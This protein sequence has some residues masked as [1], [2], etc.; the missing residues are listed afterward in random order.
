MIQRRRIL[1]V[2]GGGICGLTSA[3]WLRQLC[4]KDTTFLTT[5]GDA[6]SPV[7]TSFAW[8]GEEDKAQS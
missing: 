2:D 7:L 3:R 1:S 5:C 8:R 4:E 6:A